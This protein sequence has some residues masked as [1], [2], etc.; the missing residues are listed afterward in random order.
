M[1]ILMSEFLVQLA[2][3]FF[4]FQSLKKSKELSSKNFF[5]DYVVYFIVVHLILLFLGCIFMLLFGREIF[6]NSQ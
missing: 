6:G 2:I 4:T 3:I 1:L 5:W